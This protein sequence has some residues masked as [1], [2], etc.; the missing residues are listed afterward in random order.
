MKIY[1]K[2]IRLHAFHGVLEQERIVGNDYV[3]SISVEVPD[4]KACV[5]DQVQDTV[6]Y[7]EIAQLVREVMSV[8]CNLLESVA[9]KI[10]IKILQQYPMAIAADVDVMKVAPPMSVDCE[11]A[12]VS[13]HVTLS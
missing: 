4:E 9:H 6:N 2:N 1:V 12:G 3:V 8:P 5:S 11:G 10:G 13:L 7:A